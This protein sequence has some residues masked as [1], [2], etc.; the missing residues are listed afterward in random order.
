M[1]IKFILLF[2][3]IHHVKDDVTGAANLAQP[4]LWFSI[5]TNEQTNKINTLIDS[6]VKI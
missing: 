5:E 3:P 1:C 6:S 4:V 2:I